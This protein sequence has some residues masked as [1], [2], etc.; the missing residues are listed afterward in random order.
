MFAPEGAAV[1]EGE[2]TAVVA[3]VH[4][5]YEWARGS[6]GDM[7]PAHSLAE[8]LAKLDTLLAR[9]RIDRLVVAGDL[10]ETAFPCLRTAR[11]VRRLVDWLAARGVAM[12]PLMGNHDRPRRPPLPPTLE[13]AGWTIG[14]GHQPIAGARIMFGH[15]HPALKAGGLSA[16]CFLV[17]PRAIALPAFTPN[18]AGLDV[19]AF[20]V[21]EVFGNDS[22]RCV[23]G[24]GGELL[25][26]GPLAV[27]S[28]KLGG[29]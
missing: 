7:V 18:A 4:L 6:G 19:R 23:A 2:R 28:G 24:T 22:P 9:A 26:F 20:P 5:G 21:A 13:V 16:P 11:D 14:H 3:D 27:L 15:H 12:L 1:H 29:R 8:T 25:D 10:T 17:G